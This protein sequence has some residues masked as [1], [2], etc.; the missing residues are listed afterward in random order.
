MLFGRSLLQHPKQPRIMHAVFRA[1][2]TNSSY[3]FSRK[4]FDEILSHS[5][6]KTI[7]TARLLLKDLDARNDSKRETTEP[8]IHV[9]LRG[10]KC[11]NL[12]SIFDPRTCLNHNNFETE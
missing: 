11:E 9:K 3:K 1:G 7:P 6:L 12:A 5:S 4:A 2:G 10:E 8:L